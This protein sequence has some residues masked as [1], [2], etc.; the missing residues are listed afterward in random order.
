MEELTFELDKDAPFAGTYKRG[1][2]RTSYDN[3]VSA[4]GDPTSSSPDAGVSSEWTFS[5]SEGHAYHVYDYYT[6]AKSIPEEQV[7]YQIGTHD[8]SSFYEFLEWLEGKLEE[9]A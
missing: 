9:A 8:N 6:D 4:F 7:L 3:M 2:V 1:T 5:D